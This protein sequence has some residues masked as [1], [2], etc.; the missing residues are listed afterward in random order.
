MDIK[1]KN[2]SP[3]IAK[4]RQVA[5]YI[6]KKLTKSPLAEIG[7]KFGGK[8]HTTVLHSINKVEKEMK[9]NDE[10]AKEMNNFIRFFKE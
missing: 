3:K 8:H 5:M 9:T 2:N 10:F 6:C 7:N 4:P 1:S